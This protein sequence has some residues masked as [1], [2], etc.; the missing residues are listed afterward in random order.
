MKDFK[1]TLAYNPETKTHVVDVEFISIKGSGN[2]ISKQVRLMPDLPSSSEILD[3][4]EKQV[5]NDKFVKPFLR[6]DFLE[7][8]E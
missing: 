7:N 1:T 6:S 5:L 2:Q 4:F 8:M 3:G